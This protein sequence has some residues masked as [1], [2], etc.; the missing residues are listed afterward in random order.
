MI[1][2]SFFRSS[3][4]PALAIV[5]F[6][7]VTGCAQQTVTKPATT[8]APLT[9][10]LL[11]PATPAPVSGFS[12]PRQL[13]PTVPGFEI[14]GTGQSIAPPPA[15]MGETE[16]DQ[17][18]SFN[19]VNASVTAVAQTIFGQL[20]K[21]NYTID[22]GVQGTITLQ[23]TRPLSIDE[24]IPALETSLQMANL[25]LTRE[26]DGYHIVPLAD[27]AQAGAGNLSIAGGPQTPGYGYEI[28]PLKYAN[29]A[30]IEKL[31]QPLAQSNVQIQADTAHNLL[32]VAGTSQDRAAI[33]ANVAVFDV[34]WLAG[35][36]YALIPMQNASAESVVKE[37]NQIIGGSD[38]PMSGVVRLVVISQLNAV[39]VISQQ[40]QYL[41]QV[42]DWIERLDQQQQSDER[43]VFIYRVQNGRAS[44]IAKTLD[45]LLGQSNSGTSSSPGGDTQDNSGAG[46]G[47]NND[48][49]PLPVGGGSGAMAISGM[50]SNGSSFGAGQNNGFPGQVGNVQNASGETQG[51]PDAQGSNDLVSSDDTDA[52]Q[53]PRITADDTNNALL[54]YATPEQ[55][56]SLE[57]ALQQLD[58]EPMQVM[59]EAAVAEVTLTNQLAYGVQYFFKSGRVESLNTTGTTDA[60]AAAVPGFSAILSPG[61]NI[62]I[63]LNAL[64][65]ITHV[66]VLSAP[67]L[68]V[69]NNEP[70]ELDV[71]DEVPITTQT[72]QSTD[73]ASA[74]LVSTIQY[75]P[76]GVI[77][78]VTP[79]INEGGLVTLDI[80][81][82]VSEVS[83]TT[84][85][86]LN[87]PT[88]SERKIS[89]I[90]AVP[91]DQTV[92]L[93]GLIQS[94]T[95]ASNGGIP[96]L[97]RIPGLGVLFSNRDNSVDRT[98]LMVLITPHVVQS[99]GSLQAVTDTL[100][101]ELGDVQ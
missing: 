25:A 65:S 84:S 1:F 60:V 5:T 42:R 36:S 86:T 62:Q 97:D 93:G 56:H 18:I 55:Y 45:D 20:L 78:H 51:G 9:S 30:S 91:D 69:L 47:D 80:S 92:A 32:I 35:M 63:I 16:S 46:S 72:A 49:S 87:S 79:R 74:P 13:T 71:G 94:T 76:T 31:I 100:R 14:Y 99:P 10:N 101:G 77:L 64:E 40:A 90:V 48:T 24:V 61:N 59:I 41:S 66:D 12:L 85:S 58:V 39:L 33:A 19:F 6:L 27:A 81:Q 7:S 4:R 21:E 43:Q 2:F 22:G 89:T 3:V 70:A 38:S 26:A 73:S 98:E 52:D 28:I 17:G 68:L 37:V 54:I 44:D 53:P 11:T 95:T 15:A 96:L 57:N 34:N 82:E 67:K 83:S 50:G 75:Q 8:P 29:A 88:I 23:T